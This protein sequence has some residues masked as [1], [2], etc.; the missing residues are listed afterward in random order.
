[1]SKTGKRLLICNRTKV[2]N[3]SHLPKLSHL[4]ISK[5]S[6]VR[7]I[8]VVELLLTNGDSIDNPEQQEL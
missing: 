8:R 4:D 2:V 3:N 7:I 6:K 5:G 1:M